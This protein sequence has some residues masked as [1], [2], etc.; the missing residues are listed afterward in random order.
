MYKKSECGAVSCRGGGDGL[1]EAGGKSSPQCH[2]LP[3]I[4]FPFFLVEKKNDA[5]LSVS[6]N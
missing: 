1:L 4:S 2:F 3:L 5:F 6:S